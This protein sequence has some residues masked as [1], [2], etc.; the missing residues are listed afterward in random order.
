MTF[1]RI[2]TQ[3]EL[4]HKRIGEALDAGRKVKNSSG[5]L[6]GA[7]KHLKDAEH[8]AQRDIELKEG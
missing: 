2:Y 4:F 7:I 3:E 6:E 1:T 8:L 5:E